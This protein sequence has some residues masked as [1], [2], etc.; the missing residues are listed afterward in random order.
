MITGLYQI[1]MSEL[2]KGLLISI[3]HLNFRVDTFSL[4]RASSNK[5]N[6][7]HPTDPLILKKRIFCLLMVVMTPSSITAT[8]YSKL[9][10]F[11]SFFF[12]DS[13]GVK[14]T[15]KMMKI[16]GGREMIG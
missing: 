15:L 5:A 4:K 10:F 9:D 14:E 3:L 12:L 13:V 2:T 8:C 7:F 16:K 6:T 11:S 1:S